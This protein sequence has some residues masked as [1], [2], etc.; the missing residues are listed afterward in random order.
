VSHR[1]YNSARGQTR[2]LCIASP[3]PVMTPV[4]SVV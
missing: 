1:E 2:A 4:T 3:A